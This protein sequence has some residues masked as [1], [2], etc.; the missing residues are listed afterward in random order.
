MIEILAVILLSTVKFAATFPFA[1]SI[2]GMG[3]WETIVWTNLGGLIGIIIFSYLSDQLIGLRNWVG[4][5]SANKKDD[6]SKKIIINRKK[7]RM[8]RIKQKHGL[9]G[10]VVFTPVILSIPVGAFLTVHYYG[11]N[12]MK[13]FYLFCANL[14][15]SLIYTTF[16]LFFDRQLI[17]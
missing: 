12:N 1:I 17:H 11:K 4:F 15:W 7:R 2:C 10:I 14:V 9:I 13:M 6:S 3:F 5:R 16:Y 8:V